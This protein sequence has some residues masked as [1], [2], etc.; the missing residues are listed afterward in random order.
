MAKGTD[1]QVFNRIK[2]LEKMLLEGV[3]YNDILIYSDENWGLKE[4]QTREY[5]R[6]VYSKWQEIAE[7]DRVD[8]FNKAIQR[9]EKMYNE[10][11][12]SDDPKLAL[13]IQKDLNK[14]KGLYVEQIAE[15]KDI[16]ITI[17]K[18]IV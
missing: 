16:K 10:A 6:R 17:E 4:G 7:K 13:E 5:I 2:E 9:E 3:S 1:I 8:N 11:V 15:K 12:K 14:L 18:K